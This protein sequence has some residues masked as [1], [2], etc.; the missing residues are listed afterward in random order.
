MRP[1]R[2][3]FLTGALPTRGRDGFRVL[4]RGAISQAHVLLRGRETIQAGAPSPCGELLCR[5]GNSTYRGAR[6]TVAGSVGKTPR[7]A[8]YLT[9]EIHCSTVA[10]KVGAFA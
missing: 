10:E 3:L 4:S 2:C 8:G 6:S 1:S 9:P 7:R 5:A